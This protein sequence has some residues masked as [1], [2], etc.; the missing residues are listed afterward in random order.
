MAAVNAE[1]S[2]VEQVKTFRV[3][4]QD[5]DVASG[6]I[7]PTLKIKRAPILDRYADLVEQMYS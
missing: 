2:T 1:L 6:T 5:F 7:T 3:L 4:P